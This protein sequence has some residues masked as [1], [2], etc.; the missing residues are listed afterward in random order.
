MIRTLPRTVLH[1]FGPALLLGIAMLASLAG[2]ASQQDVAA[3]VVAEAEQTLQ[4]L[5]QEAQRAVPEQ[6]AAAEQALAK[7]RTQFEQ[8]DFAS[9]IA[10]L[11]AITT[12]LASLQELATVRRAE[13]EAALERARADWGALSI[14]VPTSLDALQR[15]I[16]EL[17]AAGK[18][19]PGVDRQTLTR[20]RATL[21][22]LRAKWAD[23]LASFA[24]GRLPQAV[25][26]ARGSRDA[27]DQLR[28]EL[29]QQVT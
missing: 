9:V 1:A 27:I 13:L 19:P 29:G 14:E 11:P 16:D 17:A 23:A 6:Y 24:Q 22:Q 8:R 25:E 10:A 18:L 20:A 12:Q 3:R 15:R 26:E 21:E 4:A 28:A 2:C 7:L 5:Q